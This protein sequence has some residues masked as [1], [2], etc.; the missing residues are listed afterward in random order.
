[1]PTAF[2]NDSIQFMLWP[3]HAAAPQSGAL[4]THRKRGGGNKA[5]TNHQ[6]ACGPASA[7]S[8]VAAAMQRAGG[9]CAY[10]WAD[11]SMLVIFDRAASDD[12]ASGGPGVAEKNKTHRTA[13]GHW[14]E[15]L[16]GQAA[17]R[18]GPGRAR[19]QAS[20]HAEPR[21]RRAG[22]DGVDEAARGAAGAQE[23]GRAPGHVH[24]RAGAGGA[25]RQRPRSRAPA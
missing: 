25:C 11:I 12:S 20:N 7:L 5:S 16:G 10:R 23:R 1:M 15:A 19:A 2:A 4:P 9:A 21:Q 3:A 14:P 18:S 22:P 24:R 17:A 13:W 8:L 6:L